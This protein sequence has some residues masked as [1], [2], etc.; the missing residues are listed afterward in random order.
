M[1]Q[2]VI[3]GRYRI[4]AQIGAGG[5]AEVFRGFDTVLSRPVAVKILAPQFARDPEFV[6][7]FRREARAAA[8]LNH[9]NVVAV[10]DTGAA[11]G[12]NFIVM[13]YVEGRTLADFLGQGGKLTPARALEIAEHVCDAL[14][15]AHAQGVVHRDV[16]T[17]NI[18]I[19]R[20]GVVKVMDF[21]IA[22][23]AEGA[24]TLAQTAAVLGTAA[25]L[26]PEQAQGRPVDARS[27]IYS[28]GVVLY[29]MVAGRP[30]FTGDSPVAV[31]Y[32]HVQES[33][34]PP[35][36]LN[37]EVSPPLDAVVMRALAKNPANRYASAVK[38]R[39]D[40]ERVDRGQQPD[41]TPLLPGAA[42]PTQVIARPPST[43]VLSPVPE[44]PGWSGARV[45]IAALVSLA[46]LAVLGG[47]L[48]LL[49][50]SILK[51]SPTASPS[52]SPVR[53]PDET[54]LQFDLAKSKLEAAG[55]VVV[56]PRFRY[57][58][59]AT[60]G[61][62]V[63]MKPPAGTLLAPGS[64]VT[65]TVAK[66]PIVV[67][68]L[69]GLTP[70]QARD[71]L[72]PLGLKLAPPMSGASDKPAGTIIFQNPPA[73]TGVKPGTTVDVTI[74]SGPAQVKVPDV[75]CF[76]YGKARSQ[77]E[78]LGLGIMLGDPAP[79]LLQCPNPNKIAAQEPAAGTLVNPGTVVTVSLGI[80]GSPSPSG[81]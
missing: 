40:L 58:G 39:D 41:A 14:E 5:M 49:A 19:T 26:S 80:G 61:T 62:V 23:I 10:Y 11:D 8:R 21:G 63:A 27:D 64:T 9:P 74:S 42:D 16:K 25:Y 34:A 79:P 53:L 43:M 72:D 66:A 59:A 24:Q 36:A 75:T 45:A 2:S 28:L 55:F 33:P 67:P 35:S 81:D 38:F 65:L 29:E 4:E 68:N 20:Q 1:S 7:R 73:E 46:I 6:E 78:H 17:A 30:P 51:G 50:N 57:T 12:T 15:A 32:K 18:M 54:T 77:L 60:P 69:I 37:P 47:G 3:G 52:G 76:S 44:K 31:A 22:R 70:A 13:E 71:A 56:D 48:F